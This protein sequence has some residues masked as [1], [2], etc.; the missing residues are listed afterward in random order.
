M[1]SHTKCQ[2]RRIKTIV[3][4]TENILRMSFNKIPEIALTMADKGKDRKAWL[5]QRCGRE[6]ISEGS[7]G[8]K[9]S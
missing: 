7:Q 4:I 6:H 5:I 8:G 9:G 2:N 1:A 3:V